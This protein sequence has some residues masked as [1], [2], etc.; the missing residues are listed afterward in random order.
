MWETI[1]AILI[2]GGFI[3]GTILLFTSE[4]FRL[5][6]VIGVFVLFVLYIIVNVM[7]EITERF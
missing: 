3:W 7:R 5:I 4:F 2:L 6:F 1:K